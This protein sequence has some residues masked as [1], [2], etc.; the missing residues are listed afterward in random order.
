MAK[1]PEAQNDVIPPGG[2]WTRTSVTLPTQ[3]MERLEERRKEVNAGREAR[4]K[5]SR[6]RFFELM[7]EWAD[8]ELVA[9]RKKK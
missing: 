6:D 7:L 9:Q 4:D 2:D 3:L 5:L 8:R 1:A